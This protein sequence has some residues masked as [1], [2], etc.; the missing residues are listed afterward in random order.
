M[1]HVEICRATQHEPKL[2][3]GKNSLK[4][5]MMRIITYLK[6]YDHLFWPKFYF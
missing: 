2:T 4:I 5:E 6:A 3:R 1:E